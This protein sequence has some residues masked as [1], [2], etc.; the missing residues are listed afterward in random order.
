[1]S[2]WLGKRD[3]SIWMMVII[4]TV[5]VLAIYAESYNQFTHLMYE[6]SASLVQS[7]TEQLS[8]SIAPDV[9]TQNAKALQTEISK[10]LRIRGI[11][12]V[13]LEDNNG[14][15]LAQAGKKTEKQLSTSSYVVISTSDTSSS[16]LGKLTVYYNVNHET[17]VVRHSGLVFLAWSL[18]AL[19]AIN[20]LLVYRNI[21]E[22]KYIEILAD[23]FGSM[24]PD[25]RNVTEEVRILLTRR[26]GNKRAY[27]R[28]K[29]LLSDKIADSIQSSE[30]KAK[31]AGEELAQKNLID[32]FAKLAHDLRTPTT[33]IAMLARN[34]VS[35]VQN[36]NNRGAAKAADEIVMAAEK[37][38]GMYENSTDFSMIVNGKAAN[39]VTEFN[40]LDLIETEVSAYYEQALANSQHIRVLISKNMPTSCT[41]G[42]S[43]LRKSLINLLSNAIKYSGKDKEILLAAR[44]KN[45]RIVID[46]YDQGVGITTEDQAGMYSMFG[47]TRKKGVA[48]SGLG[49]FIAKSYLTTV[50]GTIQ[51]VSSIV[52]RGSHFRVTLP[53]S[54]PSWR[55]ISCGAQ[56]GVWLAASPGRQRNYI[57]QILQTRKNITIHEF[58]NSLELIKYASE[59]GT[60]ALLLV[61]DDSIAT[62][63]WNKNSLF[64]S[65]V[66]KVLVSEKTENG[67][68]GFWDDH[69]KSF[70]LARLKKVSMIKELPIFRPKQGRVLIVDDDA[71][72]RDLLPGDLQAQIGLDSLAIDT[73]SSWED[74]IEKLESGNYSVV[75]TDHHMPVKNGLELSG[76]IRRR[77]PE[78]L[79]AVITANASEHVKAE[80]ADIGVDVFISKPP[81]LEQLRSLVDA[82]ARRHGVEIEKDDHQRIQDR[83]KSERRKANKS[84][85]ELADLYQSQLNQWLRDLEIHITAMDSEAATKVT[86]QAAGSSAIAGNSHFENIFSDIEEKIKKGDWFGANELLKKNTGVV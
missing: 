3:A 2:N 73:S 32:F 1:M 17:K 53:I 49:L 62:D 78:V 36:E 44:V 39:V 7:V 47:A 69:W 19:L 13:V 74:A 38:A 26:L 48:S 54:K 25:D 28:L 56:T 52:G 31:I 85:I 8:A 11:D 51:L 5:V 14:S 65:S 60:S 67:D 46:V 72:N 24:L 86:H 59:K 37:L 23:A 40:P 33:H 21:R 84:G 15:I 66:Y 58:S 64:P 82:I 57:K 35:L 80:Y 75:I 76:I 70:S 12:G 77:W 79:V 71:L 50:E 18:T 42:E 30:K 34:L 68:N 63:M 27:K 29:D 4:N 55:K 81:K 6:E 20:I 22:K 9:V 45:G 61:A 43:A 83:R 10:V 16:N 41:G